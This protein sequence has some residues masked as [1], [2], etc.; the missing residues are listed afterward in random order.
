MLTIITI[1]Y[2]NPAGLHRTIESVLNQTTTD[3]EYIVVDGAS[4]DESISYLE[5]FKPSNFR[6]FKWISEPDTGIYNAMNK[7]I[8]MATGEYLLFINSGDELADKTVVESIQKSLLPDTE[9]ASGKLTLINEKGTIQLFPPAELTLSYCLNAGLTHPNTVIRKSLFEKYGL[10]NEE[11]KIVSDWEFFLIAGSLN[12]CKY[13][14]LDF[15][16]ARFYEDG[17]SSSNKELVNA[18]MQ[19]AIKRLVPESIRTDLNR[20][21]AIENQLSHPAFRIVKQSP[22]IQKMLALI[23]K[24]TKQ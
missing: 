15:T 11:N 23:Y 6:T 10:Y 19:A 24:I 21:Q 9:L 16:V 3:F 22:L 7:G 1:N 8:R 20:L 17:I 18:E 4:T 14:K 5:T 2:N 13:Q 12:N